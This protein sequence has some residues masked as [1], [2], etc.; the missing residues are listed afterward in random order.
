MTEKL[1]IF[2]KHFYFYGGDR[3][4]GEMTPA[5]EGALSCKKDHYDYDEFWPQD[6]PLPMNLK[7]LPNDSDASKIIKTAET[8]PDYELNPAIV[9]EM[10]R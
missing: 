1:C 7:S 4:Y 3:G 5:T 9:R 6:I 2:C 10:G 8:C